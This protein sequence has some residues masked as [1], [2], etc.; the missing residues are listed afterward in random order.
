LAQNRHVP[1]PKPVAVSMALGDRVIPGAGTVPDS[2]TAWK[3]SW[4]AL[5][6]ASLCRRSVVLGGWGAAVVSYFLQ[7]ATVAGC[8]PGPHRAAV[9]P[10]VT[11]TTGGVFQRP[12]VCEPP[13]S[14][15]ESATSRPD[16]A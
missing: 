5:W 10:R 2:E 11:A 13:P 4:Q 8:L 9:L 14:D 12:T 3:L 16:R 15:P 1:A 7:G 6:G